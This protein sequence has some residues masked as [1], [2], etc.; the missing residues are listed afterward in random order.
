MHAAFKFLPLAYRQCRMDQSER[1]MKFMS[2]I[3]TCLYR[4]LLGNI[5]ICN[6]VDTAACQG[7]RDV[8]ALGR[9]LGVVDACSSI[10]IAACFFC[11]LMRKRCFSRRTD[12]IIFTCIIPVECAKLSSVDCALLWPSITQR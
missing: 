2:I 5:A 12:R 10:F 6:G 4:L 7:W 8:D 1:S 11:S 3:K 9:W